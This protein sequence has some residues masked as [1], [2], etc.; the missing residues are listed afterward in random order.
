MKKQQNVC[1]TVIM[2][3]IQPKMVYFKIQLNHLHGRILWILKKEI[4]ILSLEKK[5]LINQFNNNY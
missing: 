3:V 2:F 4:F 1:I 5:R